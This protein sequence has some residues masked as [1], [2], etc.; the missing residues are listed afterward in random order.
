LGW[1][2]TIV[3]HRPAYLQ[4]GDFG[5]AESTLCCPAAELSAH[6]DIDAFD[7]AIVMSH[8]LA[9]DRAYL[10]VLAQA[11]MAYIGLLGPTARR[12]RLLGEL[13]DPTAKLLEGRLHSPAGLDLG[14]RGPAAIALSIV[15]EM[16]ERMSRR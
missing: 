10:G 5:L 9:S 2:S 6:V 13:G 3:D 8:H 7:L 14:G 1:V 4:R 15:A 16:Q 12:D 11:S